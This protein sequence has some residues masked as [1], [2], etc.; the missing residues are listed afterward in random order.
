MRLPTIKSY[1][2]YSSSNYGAN[3]L[4]VNF[5]GLILYFSYDTVIAFRADDG[6]VIR[7]NDWST[8]TGK[9]LNA[10]SED[11]ERRISGKE[12]EEKLNEVL[13]KKGLSQD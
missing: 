12:F 1:Y 4:E 2:R 13:T 5:E 11:K 3:A 6:L 7:K 8:T 10:I 9:H